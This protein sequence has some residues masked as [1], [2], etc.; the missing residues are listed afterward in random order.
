MSFY[1]NMNNMD[2]L[3]PKG[4]YADYDFSAINTADL[5]PKKPLINSAATS[6]LQASYSSGLTLDSILGSAGTA[7]FGQIGGMLPQV[8]GL[9]SF[10]NNP[11]GGGLN[12]GSMPSINMFGMG[13]MPGIGGIAAPPVDMLSYLFGMP[14]MTGMTGMTGMPGMTGTTNMSQMSD[15]EGIAMLKKLPIMPLGTLESN[16]A[17]TYTVQ[18]VNSNNKNASLISTNN[19]G[20]TILDPYLKDEGAKAEV[21]QSMGTYI[22]RETRLAGRSDYKEVAAESIAKGILDS[23][24]K[25]GV[26]TQIDEG[27]VLSGL[28]KICKGELYTS[29]AANNNQSYWN[30][31]NKQQIDPD[32]Q[33]ALKILPRVTDKKDVKTDSISTCSGGYISGDY[34]YGGGFGGFGGWGGLNKDNDS[35]KLLQNLTNDLSSSIKE[36]VVKRKE[37][38]G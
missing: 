24:K 9:N 15:A 32:V 20:Y 35:V 13:A 16:L 23:Y 29:A 6:N 19:S 2:N 25:S 21:V 37:I 33:E 5:T 11:I 28:Q 12:M 27:K 7:S 3:I 38:T 14:G 26:K 36:Q 8:S 31:N 30:N 17:K 4:L 10:F 34:I 22:D 1:F 18:A